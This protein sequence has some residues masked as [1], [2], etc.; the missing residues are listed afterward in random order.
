MTLLELKGVSKRFGGLQAVKDVDLLV[1]EGAIL[2]LIG[3]NGAGKTT[4]FNLIV[5][6]YKPDKGTIA[7]NGRQIAGMAPYE[8]CSYGLA[9][10][11]QTT[12]PFLESTVV[13]N[14][15]VGALLQDRSVSNARKIARK[16]IEQLE[17]Q[18]I[19]NLYG[20]ELAVP[21]RKRLEVARAL[22]TGGRLLLLDEPLAGL[23]P[24]EKAHAVELIEKINSSG[25]SI[26]IVEHDMRSIMALCKKIVLLDRGKIL[27]EGSPES[28][29]RDPKAIA[30][31]LGE[32]YVAA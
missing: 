26:I 4:L 1:E 31:Y 29:T 28:V 18:E 10:T 14:I 27:V 32:D 15:V 9:R 12:R 25:I 16:V 24:S 13:D 7:F 20:H 5:G 2:G 17:L 21:D 3:P 8:I 23:N 11:F 30:A 6:Y 19:A 22:A